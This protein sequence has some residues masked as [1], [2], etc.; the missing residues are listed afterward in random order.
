[1]ADTIQTGATRETVLS[2]LTVLSSMLTAA[3]ED[4]LIEA[5]PA[6]RLNLRLP[7]PT[8]RPAFTRHQ[9]HTFL[10]KA[11]EV[12]GLHLSSLWWT[13]ARSG[14]RI[15][16]AI[17]LQPEDVDLG[18]KTLRVRHTA[19]KSKRRPL[20]PPKTGEERTVQIGGRLVERLEWLLAERLE[21]R[22]CFTPWLFAAKGTRLGQAD[23]NRA[24]C[25]VRDFLG[26]P[27]ELVPHSM[28]HS[29]ASF[30][31]ADGAPLEFVRRQLG[32]RK[33]TTTVNLYGSHA[34]MRG[35]D[36]LARLDD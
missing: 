2:R 14:L 18:R 7:R 27:R 34:P 33:I 16:E 26:L 8:P 35:D 29:Y 3:V 10:T 13:L 4:G 15:G 24:F 31:V 12:H 30:L 6:S 1:M 11:D 23:A 9:L 17:A 22:P 20:G 32:H 21:G 5:N 25:V 19:R 36:F 28:R